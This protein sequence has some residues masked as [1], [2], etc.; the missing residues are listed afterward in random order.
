VQL[1]RLPPSSPVRYASCLKSSWRRNGWRRKTGLPASVA[2]IHDSRAL[3]IRSTGALGPIAAEEAGT[4]LRAEPF[5]TAAA[6]A[7]R[8][9]QPRIETATRDTER[10][11]H[12]VRRPDPP[13]LGRVVVR[14]ERK[15]RAPGLEAAQTSRLDTLKCQGFDDTT[16]F[17]FVWQSRPNLHTIY[18][19][20]IGRPQC[21][22]PSVASA[23]SKHSFANKTASWLIKTFPAELAIRPLFG[24]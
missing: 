4:H 21:C 12:P 13:V 11:A 5:I 3:G 6:C 23:S 16:V 17:G 1:G 9:R 20:L 15:I 19:C 22:R 8:S 14:V 2:V 7:G 18:S 24:A 10:L